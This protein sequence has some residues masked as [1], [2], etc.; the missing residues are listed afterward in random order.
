MN[1]VVQFVSGSN[2]NPSLYLM[3]VSIGIVI[4]FTLFIKALLSVATK[5]FELYHA[6]RLVKEQRQYASIEDI[7][8]LMAYADHAGH[9]DYANLYLAL[10]KEKYGRFNVRVGHLYHLS[11]LI[12]CFDAPD[13]SQT[14]IPDFSKHDSLT[15]EA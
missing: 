10:V 4:T 5:L 12:D 13:L 14:A 6:Q 15:L 8:E 1:D 9:E 7:A 2:E 11:I 3:A